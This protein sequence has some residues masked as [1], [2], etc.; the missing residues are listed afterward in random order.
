MRHATRAPMQSAV[1]AGAGA[2]KSVRGM[3][4]SHAAGRGLAPSRM[5]LQRKCD[6]CEED[7]KTLQTKLEVSEPGDTLEVE[8]DRVAD[9]VM[10]MP[11]PREG[12]G[13]AIRQRH[14]SETTAPADIPPVVGEGLRSPGAS[15]CCR[16]ARLHGAALRPRLRRCAR[17][18]RWPGRPASARAVNARVYTAGSHIVFGDGQFVSRATSGRR[19]PGPRTDPRRTAGRWIP[20]QCKRCTD[21]CARTPGDTPVASTTGACTSDTR[22]SDTRTSGACSCSSARDRR[23][24]NVR[25][26]TGRADSNNDR[27]GREGDADAFAGECSLV[28]HGR[29][30]ATLCGGRRQRST[31]PR[32]IYSR[33]RRKRS[34]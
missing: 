24:R 13:S 28:D 2:P 10:R 7:D 19:N 20:R 34:R 21:T 18:Y 29:S 1:P 14:A 25:N 11:A 27:R 32:R 6:A 3:A 8:A 33:L 9:Q 16:N 23:K 30:G 5:P 31:L 17:P 4:P 12:A 26:F 15:A 22:T